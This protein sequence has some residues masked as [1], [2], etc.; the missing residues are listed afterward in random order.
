MAALK[1]YSGVFA[2]QNS[3]C[4]VH[5]C[6]GKN[7][8]NPLYYKWNETANSYCCLSAL[9]LTTACGA[10]TTPAVE[11]D[12]PITQ[13]TN[14]P[15]DV[16]SPLTETAAADCLGEEISPIGQSIAEDYESASY[17]QVMTWFCNGADF[18]D[19][20]VALETEAQTDTSADEM[21]QMLADG[22]TWE[23]IWTLV[24][25]TD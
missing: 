13:E 10:Q 12:V 22:F 7:C 8:S 2:A 15:E 21:L 14:D 11:P 17:E 19:I 4:A 5:N 3:I 6:K 23:E 1:R 24:E 25:L 18:E 16:T 20:L 9:A